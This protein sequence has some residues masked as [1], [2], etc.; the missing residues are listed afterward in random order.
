MQESW[1][2]RSA[3]V[4]SLWQGASHTAI[5]KGHRTR[6]VA[7]RGIAQRPLVRGIAHEQWCASRTC[8]SFVNLLALRLFAFFAP[9]PPPRLLD[10][11]L[12]R[13]R[14]GEGMRGTGGCRRHGGSFGVGLRAMLPDCGDQHGAGL[15][16]GRRRE[17]RVDKAEHRGLA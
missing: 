3:H 5:G 9:P 8:V 10:D 15:V 1:W 16:E 17:L 4:F 13:A 2:E 12:A 6:P 14:L 7:A 11:I